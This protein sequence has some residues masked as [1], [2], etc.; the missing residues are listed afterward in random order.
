MEDTLKINL[1]GTELAV[2][3][4]KVEAFG[5][6]RVVVNAVESLDQYVGETSSVNYVNKPPHQ[7][8]RFLGG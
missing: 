1:N 5:T 3:S 8:W 4:A 7:A 6:S 2:D